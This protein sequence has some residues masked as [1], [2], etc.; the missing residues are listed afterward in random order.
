MLTNPQRVA[1]V[2]AIVII[3]ALSATVVQCFF[4]PDALAVPSKE[5]LAQF[6]TSLMYRVGLVAVGVVL[7]WTG[8]L[9]IM[10]LFGIHMGRPREIRMAGSGGS[11]VFGL[12][13][14]E[15]F[16]RNRSVAVDGVQ[17]LRI[18]VLQT[19]Q[20][21]VV[22]GDAVVDLSRPIPDFAAAL[23]QSIRADLAKALGI[24]EIADVAV[25]IRGISDTAGY[26]PP[27]LEAAET[28]AEASYTDTETPAYPESDSAQAPAAYEPTDEQTYTSEAEASPYTPPQSFEYESTPEDDGT[29]RPEDTDDR[30]GT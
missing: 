1:L 25:S 26:V 20:G 17:D 8:V 14:V 7:I 18:S 10:V 29:R 28:P 22:K 16:L 12:G 30:S 19:R 6:H 4:G 24:E 11:L 5:L 9:L 2:L 27:P 23:Q 13:V 15:D 21:L 3:A